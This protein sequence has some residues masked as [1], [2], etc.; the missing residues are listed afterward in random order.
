M[1][2]QAIK[3]WARLDPLRPLDLGVDRD[4]YVERPHGVALSMMR[5]ME[6]PNEHVAVWGPVGS[7][8][9]TELRATEHLLSPRVLV[10]LIALDLEL[11]L[12][13]E[14]QPWEIQA[15]LCRALYRV[16]DKQKIQIGQPL[17]ERLTA[18][19]IVDRPRAQASQVASRELTDDLIGEL[20][21]HRSVAL[22]VDGLEKASSARARSI[23]RA[24]AETAQAVSLAVVLSPALLTGPEAYEML[25]DLN[26]RSL[27]LRP[28]VVDERHGAQAATGRAWLCEVA[29][30]RLGNSSV[31]NAILQDLARL[32]GGI[33][34]T[35]LQLLRDAFTSA[36]FSGRSSPEAEDLQQAQREHRA[37]L[38]RLLLPGDLGLLRKASGTDGMEV[39]IEA[40]LR[41]LAQ[42]LLLE[43]EIGNEPDPVVEPHPL[44]GL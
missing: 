12:K 24:L 8:K 39:P 25:Q 26:L 13:S 18:A 2:S 41:L 4:L 32:S 30:R 5:F 40:R 27:A 33:P 16:A 22:L 14:P 21:A 17:R 31:S 19:G 23:V 11:D 34:R 44:L 7:G 10:T 37:S 20:R 42:G 38:R 35:F 9:S 36:D 15:S 43:Y 1:A 3:P 6:R 28:V 29:A